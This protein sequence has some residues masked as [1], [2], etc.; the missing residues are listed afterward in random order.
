MTRIGTSV[1]RSA[2]DHLDDRVAGL[3]LEGRVRRDAGDR[4]IRQVRALRPPGPASRAPVALGTTTQAA[5]QGRGPARGASRPARGS[6]RRA[7]TFPETPLPSIVK[8]KTPLRDTAVRSTGRRTRTLDTSAQL[9]DGRPLG[10]ILPRADGHRHDLAA[11]RGA[12]GAGV[13][14]PSGPARA[15]APRGVEVGFG[16]NRR[17]ARPPSAVEFRPASP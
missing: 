5:V 13:D 14:P 10:H 7:W 9:Q 8:F 15:R 12:E 2:A 16:D 17:L 6:G 4:G 11:E 3:V 1:T